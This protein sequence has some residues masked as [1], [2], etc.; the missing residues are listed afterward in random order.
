MAPK[1]QDVV[2]ELLGMWLK[3]G[4][5]GEVIAIC[6]RLLARDPDNNVV[7]LFRAKASDN[8][9]LRQV[10]TTLK[11]V[12][13]KEKMKGGEVTVGMKAITTIDAANEKVVLEVMDE[14]FKEKK[15]Q[16]VIAIANRLLK[17]NPN[18]EGAKVLMQ[19]VLDREK[20]SRMFTAL[21][22]LFKE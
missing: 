2:L 22:T 15:Y 16:E 9:R 1:D 21:G 11:D 18:S 5:L 10:Y 19:K 4:R 6:D 17:R 7:K 3:E 20:L 13:A 12:F 8:E 14:W